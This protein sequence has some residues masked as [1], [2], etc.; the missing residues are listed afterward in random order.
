RLPPG[1]RAPDDGRRRAA[2]AELPRQRAAEAVVG[3]RGG[4]EQRQ[5]IGRAGWSVRDVRRPAGAWILL[6]ELSGALPPIAPAPQLPALLRRPAR[7]AH[8]H[9]D[10]ADRPVVA[11]LPPHA[12][13]GAPR[14][15]VV[16]GSDPGLPARRG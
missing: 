2:V 4:R 15:G 5:S 9:V 1:V 13:V 16:L 8:R 11:G 10:A 14:P 6:D 7:L 3:L 12:I